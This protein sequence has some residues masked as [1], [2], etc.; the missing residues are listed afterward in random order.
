MTES[1]QVTV[2]S[3]ADDIARDHLLLALAI[4]E[5]GDEDPEVLAFCRAAIAICEAGEELTPGPWPGAS[6]RHS[7]YR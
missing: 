7:G 2:Q 1:E 4:C 5:A 6:R 3:L